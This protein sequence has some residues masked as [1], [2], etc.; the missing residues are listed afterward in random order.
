MESFQVELEA[1]KVKMAE[2]GGLYETLQEF[3]WS[4]TGASRKAIILYS[5]EID[6]MRKPE[7]SQV[8]DE[9]ED[10]DLDMVYAEVIDQ[11]RAEVF[12]IFTD[13]K[14][15]VC[16]VSGFFLDWNIDQALWRRLVNSKPPFD[17]LEFPWPV[18]PGLS[19]PMTW[20]AHCTEVSDCLKKTMSTNKAAINGQDPWLTN[21][22]YERMAA[23]M[24]KIKISGPPAVTKVQVKDSVRGH[25]DL[26]AETV[27]ENEKR[28][29]VMTTE[30]MGVVDRVEE[31][32]GR[33][34][35]GA[36]LVFDGCEAYELPLEQKLDSLVPPRDVGW[37]NY[38][39]PPILRMLRVELGG[40]C[41]KLVYKVRDGL[42]LGGGQ[43]GVN[44][45]L[46]NCTW[47]RVLGWKYIMSTQPH[48]ISLMG[49][50]V[51]LSLDALL[52]EWDKLEA[53][54]PYL[55]GKWTEE[56]ASL[57]DTAGVNAK[58]FNDLRYGALNAIHAKTST[59]VENDINRALDWATTT[60][61]VGGSTAARAWGIVEVVGMNG[62][63]WKEAAIAEVKRR[64]FQP[65]AAM[66]IVPAV[67]RR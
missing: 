32:K 2:M 9:V 36:N 56:R 15:G 63:R 28:V 22:E 31:A 53:V 24:A 17:K 60:K 34:K 59:S 67:I 44:S 54:W 4:T 64:G 18:V 3:E 6:K 14:L 51:D 43:G 42:T 29:K 46:L 57:D 41:I 23:M 21:A 16:D 1:L 50:L 35:T 25:V 66:S 58:W 39:L 7:E 49:Y 62:Q 26:V 47:V 8:E 45:D 12:K 65:P 61:D 11:A 27:E 5:R 20:Y 48:Q 30:M 40:G 33:D 55:A 10:K 13:R 38:R 19:V 52:Y 37:I